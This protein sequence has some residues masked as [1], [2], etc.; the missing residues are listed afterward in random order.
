MV[1]V[2]PQCGCML[3]RRPVHLHMVIMENSDVTYILQPKKKRA[4]KP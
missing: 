4:I 3:D 2:A 1:L